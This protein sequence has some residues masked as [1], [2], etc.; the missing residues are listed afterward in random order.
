MNKKSFSAAERLAVW[1]IHNEKCYL[2]TKTV[3]LASMEVDHI[4]P[5]SLLKLENEK[6]LRK[7]LND[8]GLPKDFDLNSPKNWKPSCYTC[9]KKKLETIFNPTP[10]IQIHLQEAANKSAQVLKE[11]SSIS[12]KRSLSRA[13][14]II[15][16][17]TG[18]SR[19][20]IE[21]L[22]APEI[23][24]IE[25]SEET[26]ESYIQEARQNTNVNVN[27]PI[28]IV[29]KMIKEAL[30]AK[31]EGERIELEKNAITKQKHDIGYSSFIPRVSNL[32]YIINEK[33]EEISQTELKFTL[34]HLDIRIINN[35]D[36][37]HK[38]IKGCYKRIRN[39]KESPLIFQ[40]QFHKHSTLTFRISFLKNEKL[41]KSYLFHMNDNKNNHLLLFPSSKGLWKNYRNSSETYSDN[42][43][44]EKTI[45]WL[46]NCN[47]WK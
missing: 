8:Y 34:Q 37:L 23:S 36:E 4:I 45:S 16:K 18:F 35:K 40:Y 9:N 31:K 22:L 32:L 12:C 20:Q 38:Y 27:D 30:E 46:L 44:I 28:E 11:I 2:C 25:E 7:V 24:E 43:V 26:I 13:F 41:N 39:T 3:D 33:V 10:L 29:P 5:E 1:T 6:K 47:L 15:E 21:S 17:A 14:G 42:E 19:N